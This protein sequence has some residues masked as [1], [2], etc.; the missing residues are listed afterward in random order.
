MGKL[1][2]I[3]LEAS[4]EAANIKTVFREEVDEIKESLSETKEE[5]ATLTK[6]ITDEKVRAD[7]LISQFQTDF[8]TGQKERDATFAKRLEKDYAPKI[9]TKLK[10]IDAARK[11]VIDDVANTVSVFNAETKGRM[12]ELDAHISRAGLIAQSIAQKGLKTEYENASN[13]EEDAARKWENVTL[14]VSVVMGLFV[15][16]LFIKTLFEEGPFSPE[17]AIPKVLLTAILIGVARWTAKLEK[18]HS[19]EARKYKYLSLELETIAPFIATLPEGDQQTIT[20]TLVP[21]YFV[22]RNPDSEDKA[23][24]ESDAFAHP[25]QNVSDAIKQISGGKDG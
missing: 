2:A 19:E 15:I 11:I 7:S 16:G 3:K 14:G 8:N 1:G 9:S 22:G 13:K 4:S 12:A 23:V 25:A 5:T 20:K 6:S 24:E 18:R 17:T 10:E 21:R